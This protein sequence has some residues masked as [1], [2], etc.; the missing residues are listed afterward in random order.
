MKRRK[1]EV[2][3]RK[4]TY[5]AVIINGL[6]ILLI[7]VVLFAVLFVPEIK[8]SPRL[9]LMLTLLASL[10]APLLTEV[11]VNEITFV[12]SLLILG[13][14]GNLLGITKL[15]LLNMMPAMFLPLLFCQFM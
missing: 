1:R 8:T 13:I 10:V 6:Q 9:L 7:L 12:G 14:S 5:Y 2:S 11:V 4:A 3:I 15:K